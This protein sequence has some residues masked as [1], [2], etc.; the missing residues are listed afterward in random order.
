MRPVR[1]L[2]FF[3]PLLLA[4]CGSSSGPG[5]GAYV[6]GSVDLDCVPF[7]RALSGVQLRGDGADWWDAAAGRYARGN[8]P[9][10][11]AVLVFSRSRRLA[12]GHLAVVS[13][14]VSDRHILVT[15]ANWEAGRITADQPVMD[16]SPDNSWTRV[17]VWW[18]PGQHMGS[19]P[20][21]T[22]GFILPPKRTSAD[23]V[24]D[25]TPRAV[26]L[27]TAR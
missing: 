5:A 16:I 11:G 3:L 1:A 2:L 23:E 4:A 15:Q 18:P 25:A 26:R 8:D 14:V 27:A 19:S 6:G 22:R 21:A 24:A 20:Y 9:E 12:H 13:Q 17:R 7:A 10:P